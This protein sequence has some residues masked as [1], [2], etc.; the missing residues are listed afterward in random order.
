MV[1]YTFNP[2]DGGGGGEAGRS[3]SLVLHS[4]FQDVQGYP[5]KHALYMVMQKELQ[6]EFEDSLV[7]TTPYKNK[8]KRKE[9]YARALFKTLAPWEIS[10]IHEKWRR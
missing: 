10:Y 4:K 3:L 2:S 5:E 1:M 9:T 7:Y 8:K 6:G